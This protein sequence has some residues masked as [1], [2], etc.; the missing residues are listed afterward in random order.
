MLPSANTAEVDLLRSKNNDELVLFE[1]EPYKMM[2]LNEIKKSET[3]LP[4]DN[5]TSMITNL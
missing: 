5:V 4:I 2:V 1:K 3:L